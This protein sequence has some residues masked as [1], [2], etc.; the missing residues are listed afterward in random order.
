MQVQGAELAQ[1]ASLLYV[2][3]CKGQLSSRRPDRCTGS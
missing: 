1:N 3:M 2:G